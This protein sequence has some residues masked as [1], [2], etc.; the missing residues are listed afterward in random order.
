MQNKQDDTQAPL[1]VSFIIPYYNVPVDM[2][3]A[4]IDSILSLPLQPDEREIIVVDDGSDVSVMGKLG[5]REQHIIYVRKQ[6]GGVS[7]ARNTGLQLATGHYIQMVDS[8]DYLIRNAYGHCIDLARTLRPDIVLFDFVR[9]EMV[10][11]MPYEDSRL[12]TGSELMRNHNIHGSTCGYL[13]SRSI[14]GSLRYTPGI[15]FGE[16]E[17]F[18]PQLLLRAESIM[19][20][21]AKA[22]F[23]RKHQASATGNDNIRVLLR[24]LGDNRKVISHLNRLSDTIPTEERTALE[25]RVAQLTMDYIYNVIVF[26]KSPHFLAR[27]LA[28]LRKEGIFPLPDRDYTVKYVWF[29]RLTNSSL[30]RKVLMLVLPRMRKEE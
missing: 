27:K 28:H 25:R 1:T 16:D 11:D 12:M 15:L 21:T 19:T 3:A 6:N 14:L 18:T 17:E 22:Y 9:D 4:C 20:T 24:R 2:L 29:R 7:A 10:K 5:G 13:F 23:Y 8:D 30:G 26:T